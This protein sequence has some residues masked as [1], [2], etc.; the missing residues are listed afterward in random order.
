M[1]KKISKPLLVT[2]NARSGTTW[3]RNALKSIG[4]DIEHEAMGADGTVSWFFAMDHDWYPYLPHES[5]KGRVAHQED[6]RR[7]NYV[8]DHVVHI[9]R[10]PP[11]TIGSMTSIISATSQQWASE[12]IGFD[13]DMKPKMLRM[14]HIWNGINSQIEKD[15]FDLRV[16]I[17]RM[18]D[19]DWPK[20]M[21]LI[22]RKGTPYP[23][24][25]ARNASSGY[26]KARE[27]S[28]EIMEA[29]DKKLT[30]EIYKKAKRYGYA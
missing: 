23:V 2:G 28:W 27:C 21:K 25:K 12:V 1:A 24:L 14:M 20:L 3:T 22:G 6:G 15:G 16:N 7:R 9:V 4:L 26:R 10:N 5:P 18:E 8:F 17:E 29:L 11:H 13:I 30:K 19:R